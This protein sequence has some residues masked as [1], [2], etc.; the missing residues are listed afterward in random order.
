MLV[1]ISATKEKIRQLFSRPFFTDQRTLFWLW[2][3]LPAI[4]AIAKIHCRNN[5]LIFRGVFWHT[6][7]QTSLYAAYPDEYYD[8]NYYGPVFS[9][10]VAPF[11]VLPEWLGLLAWL[12]FLSASLYFALRYIPIAGVKRTLIYWFCAHELLTALFMAQ[13]NV[14]TAATIVGAFYFIINDKSRWAA[15]LI[16]L[17]TMV[18][19]YSIVALAFI[20]FSRHKLRLL[21]WIAIWAAVAF[22]L[23]MCI[24]SPSFIISQYG[25]WYEHILLKNDMNLFALHQNISLLGMIRKVSGCASYSDFWIIIAGLCLFAVPYL[26]IK[27]YRNLAFKYALLASALMFTVLFSTGSESSSY[28]IALVGVAIWY[29]SAP[30]KRSRLDIALMVFTFIITSMSPSDL[31][32]SSLRTSSIQPYALKALPVTLIWLK[33]SYEL[34]TRHYHPAT[35]SA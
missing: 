4:A 23:P 10:I 27:Q 24:S 11:A 1:F 5:F 28:I 31:F 20:I 13:F 35:P 14:V 29:W 9:L 8:F 6:L 26:R 19:L 18:K 30:W 17:G 3:A 16:V 7:G 21:A 33:L 34:A 12:V 15:L 22:V 25:E 2:M 32:P